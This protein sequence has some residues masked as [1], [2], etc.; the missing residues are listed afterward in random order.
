MNVVFDKGSKESVVIIKN[1]RVVGAA[2]HHGGYID[3]KL[4]PEVYLFKCF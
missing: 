1:I 3:C 2:Y 4:C